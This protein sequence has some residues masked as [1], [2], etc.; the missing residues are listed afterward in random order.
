MHQQPFQKEIP[1]FT[2]RFYSSMMARR[3]RSHYVDGEWKGGRKEKKKD[4][5]RDVKENAM[6]ASN[7]DIDIRRFNFFDRVYSLIG[8]ID[9]T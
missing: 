4:I 3:V 8:A 7:F 9:K 1:V 5:K 2:G 6:R